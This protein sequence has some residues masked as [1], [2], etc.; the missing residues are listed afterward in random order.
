MTDAN[1]RVQ[2]VVAPVRQQVYEQLKQAIVQGRFEGG[3]RLTERELT[4]LLGVSRPTIREALQQLV[5]EGLVQT[6]AG[7]GWVVATLTDEEATDLYEVR[8][9]LEGLAARRFAERATDEEIAELKE[10]FA[11]IERALSK[12][13]AD[14]EEMLES[15]S[16]FYAVLFAGAHT[17]T[18]V[19]LITALHLR[20]NVMRA[21]TLTAPGRP[22]ETIKEIRKVVQRIAA[23]DGEGAERECAHH[24]RMAAKTIFARP[25]GKDT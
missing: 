2:R 3:R 20:I 18:V 14:V 24:V 19:P 10:A 17:E 25:E 16:R 23:R 9:L 6:I 13:K 8:A 11:G 15:K 5:A 4:E 21:R 12:R 1:M 22:A 7:K